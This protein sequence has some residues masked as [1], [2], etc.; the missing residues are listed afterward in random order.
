[1]T[2]AGHLDCYCRCEDILEKFTSVVVNPSQ[3]YRVTDHVLESLKNE[4]PKP[5]R[6]LQPLS[7][8]HVLYVETDG[9]ITYDFHPIVLP[10][11]YF[12]LEKKNI[13]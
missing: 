8:D 7:K 13:K 11:K 4:D 12:F 2:Y 3:V 5:E 6:T 10:H 1:M 9:L